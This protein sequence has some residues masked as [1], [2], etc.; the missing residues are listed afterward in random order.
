MSQPIHLKLVTVIKASRSKNQRT[1]PRL[2]RKSA[3]ILPI[4]CRIHTR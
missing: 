2:G 1:N 4:A 3:I